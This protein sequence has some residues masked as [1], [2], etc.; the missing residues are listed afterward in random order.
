GCGSSQSPS[1]GFDP[2]RVVPASA[3]LFVGAIVRPTGALSARALAAGKTLTHQANPYLRLLGALQT[4]GSPPLDYKRDLAPWLG[5]QAGAF[6]SAAAG[7]GRTNL[8]P[9]L[10][11]VQQ[12]IL[13]GSAQASFPFATSA[14]PAGAPAAAGAVVLDV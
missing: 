2:A 13:G 11:L 6:L 1:K 4:P 14:G 5:A 7:G 12:G 9:L 3:P 8:G 10:S